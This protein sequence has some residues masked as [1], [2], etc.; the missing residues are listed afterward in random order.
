MDVYY[1]KLELPAGTALAAST[2]NGITRLELK[3]GSLDAWLTRLAEEFGGMPVEGGRPFERLEEELK[4]Y[5][6]GRLRVFTVRLDVHGTPFQE[7]VWRALMSVPYGDVVTYGELA[8]MAGVPGAARA[9]GGAMN[10]NRVP[11]VI[12]C[13]RVVAAGGKIGG[14]GGGLDIK[15]TLLDIEGVRPPY[16]RVRSLEAA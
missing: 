11:I 13:H 14:Y 7:R 10:R 8:V 9:V 15:R 12:P 4:L 2:A 16:G 6:S 1:K 5:F 3:A